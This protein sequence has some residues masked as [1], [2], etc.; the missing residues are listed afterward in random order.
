M[1]HPC[2]TKSTRPHKDG[3]NCRGR[4]EPQLRQTND[5][6]NLGTATA[7][8]TTTADRYINST[9]NR[10]RLLDTSVLYNDSIFLMRNLERSET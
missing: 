5:N 6:G 10:H 7:T 3:L 1:I 4:L 2:I 8:A 9:C